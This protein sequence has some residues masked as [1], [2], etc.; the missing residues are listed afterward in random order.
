MAG[1][2]LIRVSGEVKY[3]RIGVKCRHGYLLKKYRVSIRNVVLLF[4][5]YG[6][7]Y[8]MIHGTQVVNYHY[9]TD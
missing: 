7:E 8:V 3:L 9:A 2:D 6:A 4:T 5:G 1:G